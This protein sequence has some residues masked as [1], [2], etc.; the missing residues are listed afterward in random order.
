LR[1]DGLE[2]RVLG[3]AP[4]DERRHLAGARDVDHL[5]AGLGLVHAAAAEEFPED[6]AGG[7]DVGAAVDAL[8]AR[9]L[10]GHVRGLALE[11]PF[12]QLG[13]VGH[14][15]RDAEVA[16]LHLA[17]E[18]HQHVGGRHVAVHDAERVALVV[19]AAVRVVQRLEHLQHDVEAELRG[20][21]DLL[22]RQLAEELRDVE[23]LD[24]LHRDE[25]PTLLAAE[26]EGLHD[27]AMRQ[28]RR[29]LGL[30]D[31]HP[32]EGRVFG[33]AVE[34][35][36]HHREPR[37][38]HLGGAS[39]EV[40]LRHTAATD[41]IEEHVA[42]EATREQTRGRRRTLRSSRRRPYARRGATIKHRA[43]EGLNCPRPAWGR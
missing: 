10:R 15:A 6:D 23:A 3:Q 27:V 12:G 30:A 33:V 21:P 11:R 17:L 32:R 38:A 9:L 42:S 8:A 13:D 36:L 5:A 19:R 37:G 16:E 25:E 20:Q 22:L 1:D 2:L 40:D 18:R 4:V 24:V 39:R 14:R 31:E 29:E 28:P 7:E 43:W 41:V 35:H 34:H 26:V